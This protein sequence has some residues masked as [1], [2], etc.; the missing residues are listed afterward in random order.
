MKLLDTYNEIRK[1]IFDYFGYVEDWVVIPLDDATEYYWCLVDGNEGYGG[2]V[3]FSEAEE[4]LADEQ[5]EPFT[6]NDFCQ[7]GF[8]A[9]QNTL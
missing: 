5:G 9:G 7:N 8:I 2:I 6:L 4:K 3:R 1:Q